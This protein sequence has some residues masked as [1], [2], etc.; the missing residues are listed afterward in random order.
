MECLKV[1]ILSEQISR[2][3]GGIG[4]VKRS[5]MYASSRAFRKGFSTRTWSK[6]FLNIGKIHPR[7]ADIRL[8]LA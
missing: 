6:P 5:L 4:L 8:Y 7:S 1:A 3:G 2:E